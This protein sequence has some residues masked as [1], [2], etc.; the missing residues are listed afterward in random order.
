MSWMRANHAA[1]AP[2]SQSLSDHVLF[3]PCPALAAIESINA[4]MSHLG[5]A[6]LELITDPNKLL[7]AVGGTTLLFLGLYRCVVRKDRLVEWWAMAQR[8]ARP[9]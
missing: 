9:C 2:L 7:T 6:A 8:T 5:Q 3:A 4:V 1:A